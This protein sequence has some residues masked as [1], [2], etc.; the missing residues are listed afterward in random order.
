VETFRYLRTGEWHQQRYFEA[1]KVLK[2]GGGIKD[3]K[4]LA[5]S[6]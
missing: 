3:E 4:L 5:V 2:I 1:A 6:C